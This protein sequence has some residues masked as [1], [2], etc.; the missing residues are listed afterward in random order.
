MSQAEMDF[1]NHIVDTIGQVVIFATL[2]WF[3]V[4]IM[5]RN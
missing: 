4:K 5:R 2:C 1:V 3:M